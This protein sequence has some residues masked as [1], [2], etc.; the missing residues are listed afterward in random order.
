[1]RICVAI[2][3]ISWLTV[4]AGGAS[5]AANQLESKLVADARDGK[6]DEF[7]LLEA[8][9]IASGCNDREELKSIR[10][11][12]ERTL[13]KLRN[14]SVPRRLG[15]TRLLEIMHQTWLT[16][17]FQESCND[18]RVTLA[19]GEYNCVT[20]T[21]L[22]LCLARHWKLNCHAM[23]RTKHVF[24]ATNTGQV[25]ETTR[26]SG[27]AAADP[28]LACRK[29]SHVQLLGKLF[30]NRGI[31]AF[32]KQQFRTAAQLFQVSRDMDADDPLAKQ[33]LLAT[34][35]AKAMQL[36]DTGRHEQ[37]TKA[38]GKGLLV[39]PD[40]RPLQANDLY[41][42]YCWA[43][44]LAR[45]K[46]FSQAVRV[47][48]QARIPNNESYRGRVLLVLYR[49]WAQHEFQENRWQT[50]RQVVRASRRHLGSHQQQRAMERA[51]INAAAQHFRNRGEQGKATKLLQMIEAD[52]KPGKQRKH[53]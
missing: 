51:A 19:S 15:P 31:V 2:V 1:M 46:K 34:Y 18:L 13:S 49:D 28:R 14:R 45:L 20:S 35:N 39:A 52:P 9:L 8:S 41:I 53:L 22:Y 16:G 11:R 38:I 29:I 43:V 10:V 30:Y 24:A 17:R 4:T 47:I 26:Q 33:N 36:C 42:R 40:H 23:S 37:A 48:Q 32:H 27:A 3:A 12:F 21:A 6:L 7:T 25:V 5:H 50:A 44:K